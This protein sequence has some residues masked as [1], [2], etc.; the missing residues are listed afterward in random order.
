[1]DLG[2]FIYFC[3]SCLI[4]CNGYHVFH[5]YH[6]AKWGIRTVC[7]CRFS[8]K[9]CNK[10][11]GTSRENR[12]DAWY[13]EPLN[14]PSLPYPLS[15]LW[16]DHVLMYLLLAFCQFFSSIYLFPICLTRLWLSIHIWIFYTHIFFSPLINGSSPVRNL[17]LWLRL[18]RGS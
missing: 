11:S 14:K 3:F 13:R 15:S 6:E 9:T 4:K 12:I 10:K 8:C 5:R 16:F 7:G 1:M 2:W 18:Y 17:Y